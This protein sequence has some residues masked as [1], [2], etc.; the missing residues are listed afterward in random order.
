M[1]QIIFEM[2]G[3][4]ESDDQQIDLLSCC[5]FD[6]RMNSFDVRQFVSVAQSSVRLAEFHIQHS[7][8]RAAASVSSK[9]F[10]RFDLNDFLTC[11]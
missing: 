4:F 8:S 7:L 6:F 3:F 5:H 1:Q 2:I 10:T 11:A 9:M